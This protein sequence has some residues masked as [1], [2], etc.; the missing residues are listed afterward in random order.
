MIRAFRS[1]AIDLFGVFLYLLSADP[2]EDSGGGMDPNG[3]R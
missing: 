1:V 3:H 2:A